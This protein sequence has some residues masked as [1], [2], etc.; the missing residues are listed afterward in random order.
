MEELYI[1]YVLKNISY[2]P[3]GKKIKGQLVV[4]PSEYE[5][6]RSDLEKA[7]NE[8]KLTKIKRDRVFSA[9]S[10]IKYKKQQVISFWHDKYYKDA[11]FLYG[12]FQPRKKEVDS[13]LRIFKKTPRHIDAKYVLRHKDKYSR[14]TRADV[15]KVIE[16]ANAYS[17]KKRKQLIQRFNQEI[18]TLSRILVQKDKELSDMERKAK[19]ERLKFRRTI[20]CDEEFLKLLKQSVKCLGEC[21]G[22]YNHFEPEL[23]SL[24]SKNFYQQ[25]WKVQ[26]SMQ[27]PLCGLVENVRRMLNKILQF[28]GVKLDRKDRNKYIQDLCNYAYEF[29]YCDK[30]KT[31]ASAIKDRHFLSHK[32]SFSSN[33]SI[34]FNRYGNGLLYLIECTKCIMYI[35]SSLKEFIQ[36]SEDSIDVDRNMFL[37]DVQQTTEDLI[38][39]ANSLFPNTKHSLKKLSTIMPQQDVNEIIETK[40]I[41]DR[42]HHGELAPSD[43]NTTEIDL[44]KHKNEV[45]NIIDRFWPD[46]PREN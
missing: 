36:I 39:L 7:S 33:W 22:I 4:L 5:S 19:A 27:V 10:D 9:L 2:S 29:G 12:E 46:D 43:I 35:M 30:P 26:H 31:L 21:I 8:L 41:R 20:P 32:T 38:V 14:A 1:N 6:V 42:T 40:K 44:V 16:A 34:R 28:Y 37:A 11:E 17:H 13:V 18:S 24:S 15:R 45:D 23:L 3:I 25:Q